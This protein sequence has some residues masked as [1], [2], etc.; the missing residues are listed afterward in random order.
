MPRPRTG[1]RRKPRCVV[2]G[3]EAVVLSFFR[4]PRS[5]A[6]PRTASKNNNRK[7]HQQ[8]PVDDQRLDEHTRPRISA[9]R[10]SPAAPGLRAMPSTAE[11]TAL[12]WPS[13]PNAAA[14]ASAKPAVMID[15]C[16]TAPAGGR[17]G[18]LHARR[19]GATSPAAITHSH[20]YDTFPH[21]LSLRNVCSSEPDAF[22]LACLKPQRRVYRRAMPVA[23]ARHAVSRAFA[24]RCD[25]RRGRLRARLRRDRSSSARRR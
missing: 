7:D 12:P 15:Q 9:P 11:L 8:H 19:A 20:R 16:A 4:L 23:A 25:D 18:R 24:S 5:E 17:R 21:D 10:M 3:T 2:S 14:N 1:A 13:A 22:L 6:Q